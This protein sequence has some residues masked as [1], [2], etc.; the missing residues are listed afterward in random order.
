MGALSLLAHEPA[1]TM[2]FHTGMYGPPGFGGNPGAYGHPYPARYGYRGSSSYSPVDLRPTA[3][4]PRVVVESDNTFALREENANLQAQINAMRIM[5]AQEISDLKLLIKEQPEPA[6]APAP[7]APP[8]IIPEGYEFGRR[9][10]QCVQDPPGV[11]YRYEP[12]FD[13]KNPD[14]R[15]PQA[16]EVVIADEI[17]Q[18]PRA[19]FIHC[20][21]G[22]GWLPLTAPDGRGQIMRHLGRVE[23]LDMSQ[24][25]VSDGSI[26]LSQADS[27]A[28]GVDRDGKSMR[29]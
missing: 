15:G 10:Y 16:P 25:K 20:T 27:I 22:R 4:E 18:G 7:E 1:V 6:P 9:V 21:S 14:G 24:Y 26:K 23:D 3:A 13:R 29:Q 17:C 19:C 12:D 5:H 11:G 28:F 2:A 8:S